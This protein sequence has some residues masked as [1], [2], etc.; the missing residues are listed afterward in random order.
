MVLVDAHPVKAHFVGKLQLVQ[1]V[2][3]VLLAQFRIEVFVGQVHPRAVVFRLEVLGQMLVRHQME[4]GD[5]HGALPRQVWGF[6]F[7]E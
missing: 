3:V 4:E 5:F 7:W 1:V 2:S 6:R